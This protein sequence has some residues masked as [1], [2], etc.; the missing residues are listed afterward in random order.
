MRIDIKPNKKKKGFFT[1]IPRGP[2]DA[3]THDLFRSGFERLLKNSTK[4]VLVDLQ[5]VDYISSAGFGVFFAIQSFLK[6]QKAELLFCHLKPQVLKL[7][8]V[9]KMLPPES[10]FNNLEEVDQYL[11]NVAKDEIKKQ[12]ENKD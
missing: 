5:H 7:F 4:G 3:D 2:I 8:N 12:Q 9:M 10:I 6:K 11:L 1:V